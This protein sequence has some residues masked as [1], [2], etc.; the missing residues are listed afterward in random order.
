MLHCKTFVP[1]PTAVKD[2]VGLFMLP[3]VALPVMTLQV[4]TPLVG[5]FPASAVVGFKI[6]NVWLGP[7]KAML[8]AGSTVIVIVDEVLE[9][10]PTDAML[11]C[12]T[13]IP[14]P[15]LVTVVLGLVELVITAEP[16]ITPHVPAPVVGV[17]AASVVVGFNTQ[18]V[19]LGPALAMLVAGST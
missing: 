4:P 16:E 10:V 1:R 9:Q 18:S 5:V 3:I 11:H 15:T 13:F 14:S 19:W 2:V 8:G 7:A 12:N 17:L 6:H